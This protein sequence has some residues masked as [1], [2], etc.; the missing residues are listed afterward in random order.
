MVG[1]KVYTPL[2]LGYYTSN[3]YN[4]GTWAIEWWDNGLNIWKPW[5]SPNYGN[6]FL[7]IRDDNGSVGIGKRP[8][9][10]KLDVAGDVYAN[11]LKL[12]SDG[13]HKTNIKKL[14]SCKDKLSRLQGKSYNKLIS[15]K[16][17]P[18]LDNIKLDDIKDTVKYLTIL[19]SRENK[20]QEESRTEF[21]FIGQEVGEVFP[22]L[23]QKDSLGYYYVDY[24]GLIPVIVE[25][26]K[27]DSQTKDSLINVLT[28]QIATLQK[29]TA[30]QEKTI[31]SLQQQI[32]DLKKNC[33]PS[34]TKSAKVDETATGISSSDDNG[35]NGS[36]LYQ[37]SP[38]PFNQNTKIAYFIPETSISATLYIF[39]MSGVPIRTIPIQDKGYGSI[40]IK[41][42][43]L[44][45]GMYLYTLIVDDNEVDT[46]RMILTE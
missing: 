41:G 7:F 37:N 24:I 29:V 34:K 9:L 1:Y 19:Y 33:C 27:E 32:N 40:T 4:N 28:G 15:Q 21:G 25:A 16:G 31:I 22:E 5:P 3:G 6:Y 26:L 13:R 10:G 44:N 11:G 42:S 23:V 46:K 14:S 38:N 2:T 8:T 35:A 45:P 36:V 30:L 18:G 17:E 43:E 12:T 39:N 20:K